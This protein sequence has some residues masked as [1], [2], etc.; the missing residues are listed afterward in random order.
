MNLSYEGSL[1]LR[2]DNP[3]NVKFNFAKLSFTELE[4]L[5]KECFDKGEYN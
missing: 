4:D 2:N 1:E 5:G 3:E